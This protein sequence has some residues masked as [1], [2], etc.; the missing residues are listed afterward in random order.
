M[1]L[2]LCRSCVF[3]TN[4]SQ[5]LFKLH[6]N[7][8]TAMAVIKQKRKRQQIPHVTPSPSDLWSRASMAPAETWPFLRW[9]VSGLQP[10]AILARCLGSAP[11]SGPRSR[12]PVVRKDLEAHE[13]RDPIWEGC[14][15]HSRLSPGASWEGLAPMRTHCPAPWSYFPVTLQP[16]TLQCL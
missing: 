10:L 5:R 1:S 13:F 3:D 15:F 12:F 7:S 6:F 9:S 11:Y 14:L 2:W 4:Y 8:A 16:L